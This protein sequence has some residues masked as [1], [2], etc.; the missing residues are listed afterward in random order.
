MAAAREG[1][2]ASKRRRVGLTRRRAGRGSVAD[3]VVELGDIE[4]GRVRV[5]L[6]RALGDPT[7]KL[8][9]WLPDRHTWVDEE[10]AELEISGD[11]SRGVTYLGERLAVLVHDPLLLERP[12][13]LQ[14][15]G[16][17]ARLA[18][19]NERLQAALR[20]QLAE[21][22]DSR[23]RIVRTADEERRR[24]ERNLHDG[25]QQR[26]LGLGIALRLLRPHTL[27]QEGEALLA[28]NDHELRQ[29][30]LELRELARGIHPAILTDNGLSAAVR[31]LAGGFPIPVAVECDEERLPAHVETAAYHV[32]AE[33][34]ANTTRH[35]R[36]SEARVSVGL[37]EGRLRVEVGDDG[38]GGAN[39]NAG[40]GLRGL[41]DRVGALDGSFSIASP[42]G[43]GTII[44]AEIPCSA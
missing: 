41:A 35:A 20:A 17:A 5:A 23:A 38:D 24:L 19:E 30:I 36:A 4:P 1:L 11:G 28:Q 10:G 39:P 26:L 37:D 3:L 2:E 27:D 14:A 12:S 15:A 32:I 25:A 44:V 29:A 22:R 8:G 6:A 31:T 18:L 7:V 9:L 34:L 42:Q 43:S 33:A 13:V 21:L 16:S 40:T